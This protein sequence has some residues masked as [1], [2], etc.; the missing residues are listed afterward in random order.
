MELESVDR[1]IYYSGKDSEE[2]RRI[3][4]KGQSYFARL[5]LLL[6]GESSQDKASYLEKIFVGMNSGNADFRCRL[7]WHISKAYYKQCLTKIDAKDTKKAFS[8]CQQAIQYYRIFDETLEHNKV[9]Q[10]QLL[11]FKSEQKRIEYSKKIG[12]LGQIQ[13]GELYFIE[14]E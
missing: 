4:S 6:A 10:S 12:K 13:R 8:L 11:G 2:S 7:A 3:I 9:D 14:G 1:I 5:R